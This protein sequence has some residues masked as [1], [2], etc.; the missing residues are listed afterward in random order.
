MFIEKKNQGKM[1]KYSYL[2][3]SKDERTERGEANLQITI[4]TKIK[5]IKKK[6]ARE[7][8]RTKKLMDE[9]KKGNMKLQGGP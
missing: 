9:K 8:L 3:R 7:N 4:I 1:D 5:K 6:T 2:V